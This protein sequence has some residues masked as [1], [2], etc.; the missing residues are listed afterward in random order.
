[1]SSSLDEEATISIPSIAFV[2]VL[3]YF[4]YR[5][6]FS[7]PRPGTDGG[8][9]SSSRSTGFRFTPAQ[10]DQIAQMFPQLNRR[11]IMW[12]LHRN[13][14]SVQATTERV[15]MGRGLDPAPPSFQPPISFMTTSSEQPISRPSTTSAAKAAAPPDL[16]TRYNL[17]S[18]VNSKGKEREE[19]SPPPGWTSSKDARQ[20]MLQRRREEMILAARRKLQEKD[21]A[22]GDATSST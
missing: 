1:M 10:V 16:I 2:A 19:E 20:K 4:I 6:F 21:A 13:R 18:K 22:G 8:S 3:G 15:L 7:G 14:G 5:Y 9:T 11:D 17:Q 12:D